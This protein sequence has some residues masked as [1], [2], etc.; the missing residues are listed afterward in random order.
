M[1][2]IKYKGVDITDDVSIN[3]CYHDMYAE[4]RTDT[5]NIIFNDDEHVWDKW[6]VKTNDEISVEYG[7]IR[8]GT[9]FV[10]HAKPKNGLFEIIATSAPA[11]FSDRKSKAWQKIKLKAIGKEIAINHGLKFEAHGVD[12]VLYDYILQNNESDFAFLNK[13][14][15]LEGCAF[16]VYDKKLVMYSQKY[17]ESQTASEPLYVGIDS[18]YDYD[19]KSGWV[20]GSCKVEQGSYKGEYKAQNGSDRVY[21]P[22]LE[23]TVTSDKEADRIAK[24]MLRYANKNA[25]T[26]YMY[27]SVLT[28]YA[29]GSMAKLENERAPSWDGDVFIT[30]I[31]NDYGNGI[32]KIFFRRPLE[33]GY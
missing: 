31:R 7:A 16:L 10:H 30:H 5:L 26:G 3:R 15:I 23:F 20:F 21:I 32:S 6:G 9:M 17:I 28:G 19:D 27:S 33:G 1:I 18:N 13:R 14:C 22:P 8:T 25:Y 24:N 29:A 12:D 11:S 2:E 4:G